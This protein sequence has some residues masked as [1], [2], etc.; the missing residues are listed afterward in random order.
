MDGT[1]QS[2]DDM[3]SSPGAEHGARTIEVVAQDELRRSRYWAVR[4][5][6]CQLQDGVLTIHGRVPS[7]YLKQIAQ[8]LLLH[9]IEAHVAIENRLEVVSLDRP[10]IG[11]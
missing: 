4:H 6:S 5:A 10:A 2:A 9:R 3:P 11:E 7:Y 8:N 1:L